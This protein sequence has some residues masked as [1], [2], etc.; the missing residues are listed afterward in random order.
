MAGA[1]LRLG[2]AQRWPPRRRRV[3]PTDDAAPDITGT[4]ESRD[5]ALRSYL[6]HIYLDGYL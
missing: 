4:G 5:R 1:R 2:Q 3:T 6:T